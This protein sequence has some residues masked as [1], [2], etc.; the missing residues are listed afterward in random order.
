MGSA[1]GPRAGWG[2]PPQP[3]SYILL[4]AAHVRKLVV[5][6]FRRAAENNTPATCAPLAAGLRPASTS[7]FGFNQRF[8]N[9]PTRLCDLENLLPPATRA[10]AAGLGRP[11]PRRG[12]GRANEV[13]IVADGAVGMGNPAGDRFPGARQRAD[14]YQGSQPRWAVAHRLAPDDEAAARGGSR[15]WP[16][17]RR[18]RAAKSSPHG[19]NSKGGWKGRPKPGASPWAGGWGNP[20]GG[21]SKCGS[22]DRANGGAGKKP[23]R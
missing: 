16:N 12:R 3:S 13:L 6:S 2:G 15:G 4:S 18:T 5:R 20:P 19:S 10:A 21:H 7:G 9:P 11:T 23:K 14:F 17:S 22:Q 1:R 8:P